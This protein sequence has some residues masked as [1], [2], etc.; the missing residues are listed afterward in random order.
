MTPSQFVQERFGLN[1]PDG[2]TPFA[3]GQ[4]EEWKR[5]L[6]AGSVPTEKS[7]GQSPVVISSPREGDRVNGSVA[8]TGKADTPG[9][10]AYRLE[11]LQ[12]G[13][14]AWTQI[15]RAEA[16]VPS[17]AGLGLWNTAGLPDGT[18][19]I[20]LVLE[21]KDRGE[22]STFITVKIGAVGGTSPR[23][24]PTPRPNSTPS[25]IFELTPVP[26]P[27]IYNPADGR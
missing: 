23:G 7:D 26:T 9:F 21:D 13:G 25:G 22:L 27:T 8:I 5:Y 20:R 16:R 2:L 3:K 1:V 11:Y 15:I 10:V 14:L 24:S 6:N 19:T 18:Y 17:V 12:T 4:A